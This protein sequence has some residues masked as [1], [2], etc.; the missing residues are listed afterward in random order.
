[1]SK[2]LLLLALLALS[3]SCSKNN[4]LSRAS[5]YGA[6]GDGKSDDSKA[7]QNAINSA[8]GIVSLDK[9]VY[10]IESSIY[11]KSN[12]SLEG[13]GAKII[14]SP[15]VQGSAFI[16]NQQSNVSLKD[17]TVIGQMDW[18][19]EGNTT[20]RDKYLI[21]CKDSKNLSFSNLTL[22]EHPFTVI[23]CA[24][25]IGM[26][27]D[28]CTISN[29]GKHTSFEKFKYYSY[30][31]IIIG[32][33]KNSSNLTINA[34]TFKDIGNVPNDSNKPNDGDG[35][36]IQAPK[37][38]VV[39]NLK[40]TNNKFINCSAR[41]VK[42]QSGDLVKIS[43]NEFHHCG[44]GVGMTMVNDLS[45]ITISKNNFSDIGSATATNHKG[46][47]ASNVTITGNTANN[48]DFFYRTSG[49]SLLSNSVISDNVVSNIG[50]CFID[51]LAN[52]LKVHG[53]T[54]TGYAGKG[55]KSY[56]MAMLVA[57]GSDQI[58]ITENTINATQPTATA[59]YIKHNIN[60][61]RVEKNRINVPENT[62]KHRIIVDHSKNAKAIE[63]NII[64]HEKNLGKQ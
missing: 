21:K 48:C 7:L 60:E 36:Q 17:F 13:N 30:D 55:N 23:H 53:N 20:G 18:P 3:V 8:N 47:V 6:K 19:I 54:I 38:G 50:F 32:A 62:S 37:T 24:D 45:D 15:K 4:S 5:S 26:T 1:M 2:H 63:S 35:I 40:I 44:T 33:Y 61:V 49:G 46:M 31:G 51:A 42:L 14:V 11:L 28:N 29:I 25:I 12:T 16:I 52:N 64:K 22:T 57:A 43:S 34:C 27:I 59:I 10:V 9:K 41:G 58:E 39:S 56:H